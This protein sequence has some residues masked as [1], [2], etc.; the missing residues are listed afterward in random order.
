MIS[1]S[2]SFTSAWTARCISS[3]VSTCFV[4]RPGGGASSVGPVTRTT[5][6]PRL[7]AASERISHATAGRIREDAHRIEVLARRPG[8]HDDTLAGPLALRIPLRRLSEETF[9]RGEDRLR[10]AHPARPLARPFGERA[11]PRADN[12][13]APR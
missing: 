12:M 4:A 5:L 6:A 1:A 2:A 9:R 8:C 13:P 7:E 11:D 3:V 10:F